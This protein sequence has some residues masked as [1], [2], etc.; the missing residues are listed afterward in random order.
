MREKLAGYVR[1]MGIGNVLTMMQFG[2]LPADLTR[3]SMDRFAKEV[4]PYVK[5]EGKAF[6]GDVEHA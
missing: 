4:M 5:K 1:E 6:I 2:S 3:A